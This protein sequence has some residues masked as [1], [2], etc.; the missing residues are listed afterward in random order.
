MMGLIAK[1]VSWLSGKAVIYALILA[2]LL[3]IFMVKKVPAMV[4][5]YREKEL[6]RAIA[7]LSESK[8]LVGEYAEKVGTLSKD[9][10]EQTQRL[11]E[12]DEKRRQMEKWWQKVKNVFRKGE[13][14][15]E[16]TRID[17]REAELRRDVLEKSRERARLRIEG[18]ESEE[19]MQKR[20]LLK[21]EKEKQLR[22]VRG[23]KETFD[24]LMR[25][26][27]QQLA[28][29][30]LAVLAVII[31]V[32]LLL[33]AIAFYV[34]APLANATEPILLGVSRPNSE[35]ITVTA[36]HPAQ[37]M[38]MGKDEVVLTKVDYL[39][40]SMGNF[41][42]GTKWVMDWRYP[43]SSVAAGLYFLTKIR[44]LGEEPGQITLSTQVDATEELAVVG[45][46]EG[47]AMVFRPHYLVAVAHPLGQPPRIKSRWV[48]WKLHAWVNLQF[49]YLIVEG[50]TKLV[51]AAQR[52]L[53][54]E[55][56]SP[57]LPGRRVNSNLTVAFSPH[58]SYSP[59]RAETFVAYVWGKN[60]LFDDFFQGE[61]WVIQQ[62]VTGGK[63]NAVARIWD[64]IF[65]AI[66]KVF[67]I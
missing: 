34:V 42:K 20:E 9:I 61:G 1:C 10:G 26:Q 19:E 39:Q 6:E 47:R 54:V 28:L 18:G 66:G 4:A 67:G 33:K 38:E 62:Q 2:L 48:F 37:R 36:S 49:R 46:P 29:V 45:I 51:F 57:S 16:R 58:L 11:R 17:R 60:S 14:E 43:F 59:K 56:V 21:E 7:A 40:G 64:G 27:F 8:A 25:D 13:I 50:P 53:Q 23:V 32:P 3:G 30:A 52:G 31:L 44:N 55:S 24:A 12:L 22:D 41:E 15:T 63:K 35:D 65:G 5:D